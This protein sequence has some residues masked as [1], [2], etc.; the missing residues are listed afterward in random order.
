MTLAHC[1][2]VVAVAVW[3]TAMEGDL[4]VSLGIHRAPS[5]ALAQRIAMGAASTGAAVAAV[6]A[7]VGEFG[8]AA[9]RAR[10]PVPRVGF[11]PPRFGSRAARWASASARSAWLQ[12]LGPQRCSACLSRCP[13][14]RSQQ[15]LARVQ[16]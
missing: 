5:A 15:A 8:S 4:A 1:R 3:P 12:P 9:W 16:R 14:G 13:L 10:L 11:L 2:Y 7:E 6:R